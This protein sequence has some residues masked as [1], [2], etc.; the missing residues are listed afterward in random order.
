[1][2]R[3][4]YGASGAAQV[5]S[6]TGVPTTAAATVKTARTGGTTVTDIQ[7][8][9]GANLGGVVTPDSRGQIIFQG[10]DNSN[11]TYW[12]DF[13]DGG[14]RWAVYPVDMSAAV[15]L[16]MAARDAAQ[17]TTPDGT[18][19]KSGLPYANNSIS[20]KLAE[21]L[22]SKVFARFASASARDTAFPAPADGDRVYRTDIHQ[23]QTYR[24]GLPT[25]RWVT[26]AGVI[27]EG[28][29][30]SDSA[31][32]TFNTIPQDWRNLRILY[33][34]R[35]TGS[36]STD[37]KAQRVGIRLNNDAGANYS[38]HGTINGVKQV[39]GAITYDI[40]RAGA[41]T[42]TGTTTV[43]NVSLSN[44]PNTAIGA[45]TCHIGICGGSD[46]SSLY[47]GG[48]IVIN[49]YTNASTRKAILGHTGLGDAAGGAGTGYMYTAQI[50]GGWNNN[51]AINRIDLFAVSATAF[52]AGSYFA[53]YGW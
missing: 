13:G 25:G 47:G 11:A 28:T 48:E 18:T 26:D 23:F 35:A 29:I 51:A 30:T 9:S 1:M 49:D 3:A 32:I 7:N 34:A 24:A 53:V 14:P 4:I 45:T 27:Y 20:R 37:T 5:V 16:A 33:R 8:M 10:P 41:G 19:V 22:D 38:A 12:L 52:A 21:A 46:F 2:A 39:S 17:Y 15:T 50:Q 6:P 40:D 44:V 42:E 43:T 31:V 36:P